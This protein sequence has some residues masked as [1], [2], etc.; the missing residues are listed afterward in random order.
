M[1][2]SEER[3]Y[4]KKKRKS[5]RRE[6]GPVQ[7]QQI[8]NTPITPITPTVNSNNSRMGDYFTGQ[9]ISKYPLQQVNP[10]SNDP[11]FP[12]YP[13][14][15][16]KSRSNQAYRNAN[17]DINRVD[18]RSVLSRVFNPNGAAPS[19]YVTKSATL[20]QGRQSA[21]TMPVNSGNF[22][23]L[24]MAPSGY[25]NTATEMYNSG[26]N[27]MDNV[28]AAGKN[29]V[30]LRNAMDLAS[31]RS[32]EEQESFLK[33][34]RD[35]AAAQ[36]RKEVER[37]ENRKRRKSALDKY[38]YSSAARPDNVPKNIDPN[39]LR[40][41]RPKSVMENL[42]SMFNGDRLQGYLN[43]VNK[44]MGTNITTGG[45][46]KAAIGLASAAGLYYGGKKLYE[47]WKNSRGYNDL[48]DYEAYNW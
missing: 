2:Y 28:R 46:G 5:R 15:P 42:Q 25:M 21:L 47:G 48:N 20:K 45:L 19:D 22:V 33:N 35:K 31:R 1:Y 43:N 8:T 3:Y 24:R 38:P 27:S 18:G 40:V 7:P 29:I 11:Y 16:L 41:D 14:V 34:Q 10:M 30:D 26:P 9:N 36:E 32:E 39:T 6:R 4:S 13:E 37:V 12:E 23:G 44:V 17:Y